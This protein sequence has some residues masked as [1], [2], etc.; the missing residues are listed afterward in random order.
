MQM[1]HPTLWTWSHEERKRIVSVCSCSQGYVC[2]SQ[3]HCNTNRNNI[4]Q[5]VNEKGRKNCAE[6]RVSTA[7]AARPTVIGSDLL[8]C[9]RLLSSS[10]LL[11][12]GLHAG[13]AGDGGLAPVCETVSSCSRGREDADAENS[14]F[15]LSTRINIK[16]NYT[17]EG[18]IEGNLIQE[19]VKLETALGKDTR[20]VA[21]VTRKPCGYS[22]ERTKTCSWENGCGLQLK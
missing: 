17:I 10:L 19:D 7:I 22:R 6:W 13:F 11:P 4:R 21:T 12:C 20:E 18:T 14:L 15:E 5:S 1:L 9:C 8:N 3:G 16:D 2:F